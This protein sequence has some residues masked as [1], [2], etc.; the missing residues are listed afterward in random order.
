MTKRPT[1]KYKSPAPVATRLRDRGF[2]V[3]AGLYQSPR[4][5][6]LSFTAVRQLRM[7]TL[8]L[9]PLRLASFITHRLSCEGWRE[10]I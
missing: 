6:G 1:T 5:A 10:F 3:F 9:S 8:R 4:K 7:K 2:T